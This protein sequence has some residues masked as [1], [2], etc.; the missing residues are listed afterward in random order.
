MLTAQLSPCSPLP[1]YC[2]PVLIWCGD[3]GAL[4]LVPDRHAL[5]LQLCDEGH[6]EG[7]GHTE[8]G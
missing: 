2:L 4:I 7:H 8:Q 5:H 1:Q 3:D 6:H